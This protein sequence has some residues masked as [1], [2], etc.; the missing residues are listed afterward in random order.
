MNQ[1]S[2][3]CR[4][5]LFGL[6]FGVIVAHAWAVHALLSAFAPLVS[7]GDWVIA[8]LSVSALTIVSMIV[9]SAIG[10]KAIGDDYRATVA[11]Q[12]RVPAKREAQSLPWAPVV[13]S[14]SLVPTPTSHHA[15]EKAW[16]GRGPRGNHDPEQPYCHF[17][18]NE[19]P[20]SDWFILHVGY[21][22]SLVGPDEYGLVEICLSCEAGYSHPWKDE[23]K[24][25]Y[26]AR[27]EEQD[28]INKELEQKSES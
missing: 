1:T 3:F 7:F 24:S 9:A 14:A 18:G 12:P 25:D 22:G 20:G 15:E 21:G 16:A 17:C 13:T 11:A 23:S 10:T 8:L 27:I 28:K 2:R 19:Y 6:W 5:A 26:E 4:V